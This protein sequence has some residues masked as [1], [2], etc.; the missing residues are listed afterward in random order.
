MSSEQQHT[1]AQLPDMS[2]SEEEKV[3]TELFAEL[4]D[5]LGKI[6]GEADKYR[7]V[8]NPPI[9]INFID[10]DGNVVQLQS[11]ENENTYTLFDR[12]IRHQHTPCIIG[13]LMYEFR[14]NGKPLHRNET[15]GDIG[16]GPGA[17]ENNFNNAII[18]V[19]TKV[20]KR[21]DD[22]TTLV[23]IIS[24]IMK[25]H[26][27]SF[28]NQH[29]AFN[30]IVTDYL[31]DDGEFIVEYPDNESHKYDEEKFIKYMKRY[32][33]ELN[34]FKNDL[35][36]YFKNLIKVY[37]CEIDSMYGLEEVNAIILRAIHLEQQ[38][39]RSTLFFSEVEGTTG[40]DLSDC[41]QQ[42][43]DAFNIITQKKLT[44][45]SDGARYKVFKPFFQEGDLVYA[46]A[47]I[48]EPSWE[49]GEVITYNEYEDMD[50]Y[51]PSRT[52]TILLD[53]GGVLDDIGDY[54]VIT[55][56]EY[57][58]SKRIKESDRKGVKRVVDEDSTDR[59]AREVGWYATTI[60]EMEQTFTHLSDALR[61]HDLYA[62][63]L[64][65]DRSNMNFPKDYSDEL[66]Y[67]IENHFSSRI[68]LMLANDRLSDPIMRRI[69]RTLITFI[70]PSRI[71]ELE[72]PDRTW[73][74]VT[75][76]I[77][78]GEWITNREIADYVYKLALAKQCFDPNSVSS[79]YLFPTVL[80]L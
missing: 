46:C 55:D 39:D 49:H 43:D 27:Q 68:G 45:V 19:K 14:Y 78:D 60:H 73:K 8:N 22:D 36:L 31:E 1:E 11:E 69:G 34:G 38:V 3:N 25:N 53:N 7:E 42:L 44:L 74:L 10:E 72:D 64:R 26:P 59:W 21:T 71:W 16:I 70:H 52:Y 65:Q 4:Q 32:Y 75:G 24:S 33:M 77:Q 12:Y 40:E 62:W 51:G 30:G 2:E 66:Q 37:T 56:K 76:H 15:V 13:R 79:V 17:D 57:V 6:H 48:N 58:L 9:Y 35:T 67:E 20:P 18:Y 50:G 29:L 63:G 47:D 28:V 23:N 41:Y 80:S 61:A 54:Q 5:M